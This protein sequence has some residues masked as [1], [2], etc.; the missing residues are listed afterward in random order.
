MKPAE[1]IVRPTSCSDWPERWLYAAILAGVMLFGRSRQSSGSSDEFGFK[2][3][4]NRVGIRDRHAAI[5]N[6][7]GIDHAR[8]TYRYAAAISG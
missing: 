7:L 2:A 3:A 4:E 6:R 5:L 1:K 8:L